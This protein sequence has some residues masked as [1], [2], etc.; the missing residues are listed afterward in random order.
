MRVRVEVFGL[1][2]AGNT[3]DEYEDASWP[4]GAIEEERASL[5]LAVAD[6]ATETS[7]SASWAKLL[8]EAFGDDVLHGATLIEDLLPLQSRWKQQV[9]EKPL[10]W[11]AEEKL[12]S[13][14]FAALAGLRLQSDGT[15]SALAVGDSCIFQVRK[16]E[17]ISR[18]PLESSE[19]FDD[20]PVLISS[21][22]TGG[23]EA[24]QHVR[25]KDG[26]WK[27]GDTFYLMTDAIACYLLRRWENHDGERDL[28][29]L[30]DDV[31]DALKFG[32]FV[33]HER[34]QSLPDGRHLLRNDD[35]TVIRCSMIA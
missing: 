24:A 3:D 27:P 19:Q 30:F 18:F 10:P 15:W 2:K 33:N 16:D 9:G 21:T 7:F 14:A 34:G 17:L 4:S 23:L 31:G 12:R 1:P 8:V 20:R 5:N 22:R 35:V 11:Y 26:E 29:A 13:G 28:L 6:G 25:S 32:E